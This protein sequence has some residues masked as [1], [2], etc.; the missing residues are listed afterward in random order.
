MGNDTTFHITISLHV[1]HPQRCKG[2]YLFPLQHMCWARS[3]GAESAG[4]PAGGSHVGQCG[5]ATLCRGQLQ[6]G[7]G[8]W[9]AGSGLHP[10]YGAG[11]VR[12]CL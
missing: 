11:L 6:H 2:R 5:I 4:A 7:L 1:L 3:G 10:V 8:V 12:D 9:D